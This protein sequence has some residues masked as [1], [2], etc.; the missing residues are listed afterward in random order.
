MFWNSSNWVQLLASNVDLVLRKHSIWLIFSMQTYTKHQ[1]AQNILI[2]DLKALKRIVLTGGLKHL[3]TLA[4]STIIFV[5]KS[6][7]S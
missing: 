2:L 1:I 3:K 6:M 4:S 7:L 5:R